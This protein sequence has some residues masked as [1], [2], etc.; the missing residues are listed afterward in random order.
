M[1]SYLNF[2]KLSA[3]KTVDYQCAFKQFNMFLSHEGLLEKVLDAKQIERWL[4]SLNVKP[5]TKRGKLAIISRF[6]NY[7]ETLGFKTSIPE[8][9]MFHYSFSHM[10]FP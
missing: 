1:A 3:I 7:L 9:R 4:G 8:L 2:V 5:L 6:A 10:Y